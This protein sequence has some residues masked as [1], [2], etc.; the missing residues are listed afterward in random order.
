M[1]GAGIAEEEKA[2]IGGLKM[3]DL[4]LISGSMMMVVYLIMLSRTTKNIERSIRLSNAFV[5]LACFLICFAHSSYLNFITLPWEMINIRAVFFDFGLVAF[6]VG[7][8]IMFVEL[9]KDPM[10]KYSP[11]VVVIG[12]S[13]LTMYGN[14][15]VPIG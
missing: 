13:L 10:F 7:L 15:A 2:E 3:N 14:L 5:A 12:M 1:N 4:L 9:L 6:L 11:Y 8:F